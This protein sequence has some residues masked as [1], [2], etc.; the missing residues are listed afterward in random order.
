MLQVILN[1]FQ[2]VR[3]AFNLLL[4]PFFLFF[5]LLAISKPTSSSQRS[6]QFLATAYRIWKERLKPILKRLLSSPLRSLTRS[7]LLFSANQERRDWI[8]DHQYPCRPTSDEMAVAER[9]TPRPLPNR[10]LHIFSKLPNELIN[11]ILSFVASPTSPPDLSSN[12]TT[13][14]LLSKYHKNL[15]ESKLY[16][17]VHLDDSRSFR[18]F[19]MTMAIHNPRLGSLVESLQIS[20]REF[21]REGYLPLQFEESSPLSLGI[22]Q[23][24][25]S[26]VNLKEL[27][28][29]LFSFSAFQSGT[30][31]KLLRGCRPTSLAV[32]L[33]SVHQLSSSTFENVRE[34]R[35][36]TFGIDVSSCKEILSTLPKLELLEIRYL[37]RAKGAGVDGWRRSIQEP[38]ETEH[39]LKR[40]YESLRFLESL[41]IPS[42]EEGQQQKVPS[43]VRREE[44][45]G[46]YLVGADRHRDDAIGG[47]GKNL[48][49][50]RVKTWP[51]ALEELKRLFQGGDEGGEE[52]EASAPRTRDHAG[53][54]KKVELAADKHYHLGPRR[55]AHFDWWKEKA[56]L[57]WI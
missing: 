48:T 43:V 49:K 2:L 45:G 54:R 28:L 57:P 20:S 24:L 25:L 11:L 50:V 5:L 29:D 1:A 13:V 26:T 44:R 47:L 40:L 31:S 23:I 32:E 46:T 34:L 22:E 8:P 30:G 35:I 10:N 18:R 21:D 41:P 15:I 37:S 36:S 19:R 4:F 16:R 3:S 12:P 56:G 39:Q 53:G 42:D 14:L 9:R 55:G 33:G 52:P 38:A 7:T 17:F 6:A 51:S 27:N